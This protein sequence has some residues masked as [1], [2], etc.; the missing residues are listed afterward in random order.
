MCVLLVASAGLSD[1]KLFNVID[2]M[3]IVVISCCDNVAGGRVTHALETYLVP[4]LVVV[5]TNY[6]MHHTLCNR[7]H[8]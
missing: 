5:A 1:F 3:Y 7:R 8:V 2:A 4:M 6:T